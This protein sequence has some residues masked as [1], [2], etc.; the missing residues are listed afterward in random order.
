[1]KIQYFQSEQQP[2][3]NHNISIISIQQLRNNILSSIQENFQRPLFVSINTSNFAILKDIQPNAH[4][5]N[6]QNF[7]V[8]STP[9][10]VQ[11]LKQQLNTQSLQ[12][13]LKVSNCHR[14]FYAFEI[15]QSDVQV[16]EQLFIFLNSIQL[17][18]F[19]VENMIVF[20]NTDDADQS[21][22]LY[23]KFESLKPKNFEFISICASFHQLQSKQ[24]QL[25][26]L[27]GRLA[28]I[29]NKSLVVYLYNI[30]QKSEQSK[31]VQQLFLQSQKLELTKQEMTGEQ[32]E[33]LFAQPALPQMR[34]IEMNQG[35]DIPKM[36][37]IV[38]Q[39][40]QK[41]EITDPISGKTIT[42]LLQQVKQ[43]DK[44]ESIQNIKQQIQF[45]SQKSNQQKQQ[46][47]I[48]NQE[49]ILTPIEF[50]QFAAR[51]KHSNAVFL[52][53]LKYLEP[54]YS[55]EQLTITINI[56]RLTDTNFLT[57]LGL[58][59]HHTEIN[60]SNLIALAYGYADEDGTGVYVC[61][62]QNLNII[63]K[64]TFQP[65]TAQP[66][67]TIQTILNL[68]N[69]FQARSYDLLKNN[70]NNF[71]DSALHA[72]QSQHL[73]DWV[74]RAATIAQKIYKG[75]VKVKIQ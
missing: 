29:Y 42:Q 4:L 46:I 38:I 57:K 22:K 39:N 75:R 14:R 54:L 21:G 34:N 45:A 9:F 66:Q 64:I 35:I 49:N 73:P 50:K 6:T 68:A 48:S 41:L 36:S 32:F 55:L 61:G 3:F 10:T 1:M 15:A 70:C 59:I 27:Y 2:V 8:S 51:Y 7:Q 74:N 52:R 65:I 40:S 33:E 53:L 16:L 43:V 58:G 31:S 24:V 60:F 71:T 63:D 19:G 44:Q 72:F 17:N 62:S 13:L 12:I 25:K 28:K 37:N 30:M 67:N 23:R 47:N 69:R 26:Q 18:K 11:Q 56:Y 5:I 20:F